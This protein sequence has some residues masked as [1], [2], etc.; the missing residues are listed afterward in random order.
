MKD[1]VELL[2]FYNDRL[3]K[4]SLAPLSRS[5]VVS[6]RNTEHLGRVATT[7]FDI[8][9]WPAAF[10]LWLDGKCLDLQVRSS[11]HIIDFSPTTP[12]F[13]SS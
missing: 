3:C 6:S 1:R 2:L 5:A 12:N 4:H 13:D 11:G 10:A 9:S 8:F 7:P